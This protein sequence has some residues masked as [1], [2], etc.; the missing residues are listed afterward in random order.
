M[1]G[2]SLS[3]VEPV[4]LGSRRGRRLFIITIV[5][6][7]NIRTSIYRC[8]V[9]LLTRKSSCHFKANTTYTKLFQ[10]AEEEEISALDASKSVDMIFME[11][12]I[13][14]I[15]GSPRIKN[16]DDERGFQMILSG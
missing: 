1:H 6:I 3:R 12:R 2:S 8:R 11:V 4:E 13:S 7:I 15:H 16:Y 5:N 10:A 9:G 14:T